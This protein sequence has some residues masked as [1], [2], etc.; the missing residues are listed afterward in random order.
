M[1]QYNLEN[2][3]TKLDKLGEYVSQLEGR[4]EDLEATVRTVL[5]ENQELKWSAAHNYYTGDVD[6]L[7]NLYRLD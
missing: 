1:S 7:E 4:I 3:K 2:R 6:T 5:R